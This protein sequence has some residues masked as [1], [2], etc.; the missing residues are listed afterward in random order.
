M[1]ARNR[2]GSRRRRRRSRLFKGL[3]LSGTAVGLPALL[4]AVNARRQQRLAVP[5]WG[6]HRSY[7]WKYGE[8]SYQRLGRGPALTLLHSFGPGHDAEEWRVFAQ[9]LGTDHTLFVPDLLG[10]G[11]SDKPHI[12]YDS[13]LYLQLITEFLEDV[14]AS[15]S[16]VIAA[17]SAAAYAVRVAAERPDLVSALA[18]LVPGGIEVQRPGADLKRAVSYRLLRLPIFRTTALNALTSRS[19]LTQYLKREI[20]H[21]D[22]QVDVGRVEHYYRSSHQP[23]SHWA[24]TSYLR[25]ELDLEIESILPRL[26]VPLWIGW[27][28]HAPSPPVEA[29][30][31]WLR[32]APRANL[33]VLDDSATLPHL[34]QAGACAGLLGPFLA[35]S[36]A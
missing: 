31:L 4:N 15:R 23:G 29:A 2:R 36:A 26:S 3:L 32:L 22:E 28:R 34:E 35:S 21:R 27:G 33:E 20:F 16:T 5:D 7:P 18:L 8:I 9:I 30:D 6:R 13:A 12:A 17:G 14:L 10:W 24:L 11:R 25:G 19:A 1:V